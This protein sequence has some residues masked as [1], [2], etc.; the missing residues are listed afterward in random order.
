MIRSCYSSLANLPVAFHLAQSEPCFT[1]AQETLTTHWIC[2]GNILKRHD[3][4]STQTNFNRFWGWAQE[5]LPSSH[6]G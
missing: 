1:K 6:S 2:P 3:Q 5:F 4:A